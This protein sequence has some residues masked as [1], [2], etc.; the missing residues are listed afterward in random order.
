M[1]L[2]FLVPWLQTQRAPKPTF[3]SLGPSPPKGPRV[4]FPQLLRWGLFPRPALLCWPQLLPPPGSLHH[5]CLG[6]P[7]AVW[8]D[9]NL[10]NEQPML[11]V[12]FTKPG[13]R[14][15]LDSPQGSTRGH[16]QGSFLLSASYGSGSVSRTLHK[17]QHPGLSSRPE[18]SVAGKQRHVVGCEL[19]P[20]RPV[21][22]R[23]SFSRGGD[24]PQGLC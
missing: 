18:A 3:H 5:G 13:S 20:V 1:G 6:G 22:C 21:P 9:Q 15:G 7:G 2:F 24:K 12:H 17:G 10:S 16:Y 23:S 11:G 14:A 19:C 4:T 8:R